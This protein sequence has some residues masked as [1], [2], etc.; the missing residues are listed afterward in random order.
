MNYVA[1]AFIKYA[2]FNG[3]ARRSEYWYFFFFFVIGSMVL[4]IVD[5][6]IGIRIFLPVFSLFLI[7][8]ITLGVR[9]M[10]DVGKSGWFLLIPVYNLILTITKGEKGTNNYG[11]DPK[12][13]I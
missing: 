12:Y 5:G 2:D 7:P 11:P 6:L 8:M 4:K 10:H 9:R 3:R 13:G 1:S